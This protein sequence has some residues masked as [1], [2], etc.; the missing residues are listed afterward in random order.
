MPFFEK[1]PNLKLALELLIFLAQFAL[2]IAFAVT[3]IPGIQI[4]AAI[5]E[6]IE[7][8]NSPALQGYRP[9]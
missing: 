4:A 8:F 9:F 6:R 7:I 5:L 2:E 1:H 3:G